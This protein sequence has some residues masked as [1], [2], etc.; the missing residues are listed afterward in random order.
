MV[1]IAA[2]MEGVEA[3]GLH[4]GKKAAKGG[5]HGGKLADFLA[6][7]TAR[8]DGAKVGQT[9]VAPAPGTEDA[10]PLQPAHLAA[11]S[12]PARPTPDGAEPAEL[13]VQATGD[14]AKPVLPGAMALPTGAG[15]VEAQGEAGESGRGD[16]TSATRKLAHLLARHNGEAPENRP[17]P[18]REP[19]AKAAEAP[20][21]TGQKLPPA[22]EPA[23]QSGEDQAVAVV[24]SLEA[25]LTPM[26]ASPQTSSDAPLT[27]LPAELLPRAVET[28]VHA[29]VEAPV[30]TPAFAA[31]FAEKVVWLSNRQTQVAE[32]S[33]NPP[34]LGNLEVRLTVSPSGEAGAQFFSPSPVVRDAIESALP[35]LKEL[36]AQA[37]I[38]LGESQVRDQTLNQGG[39]G[40]T[41]KGNG[42][43]NGN[44]SADGL[45]APPSTRR[46]AVGLVDLYA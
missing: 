32:L 12:K 6:A 28:R 35:R 27:R 4:G 23:V 15:A 17:D 34:Q 3:A 25:T 43:G 19:A 38:Q 40:E 24:D 1:D 42:G 21:V 39:E 9:A 8:L 33:L 14:D 13:L 5:G 30:K 7:F 29:A 41:R 36:M 18:T 11:S 46:L 22:G 31:E 37:G 45:Q 26:T 44:A 20:E 10:E 2:I 16:V